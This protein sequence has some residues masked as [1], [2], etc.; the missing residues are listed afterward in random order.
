[1]KKTKEKKLT[2]KEIQY[3]EKEMLRKIIDFFSANNFNYYIWYGTFLGAVR[4]KGFIPWD[5]DIDLVMLRPEYNKLVNYLIAND[6]KI[7]DDLFAEGYELGNN[8]DFIILK[9]YNKN[10]K[11][12]D[13]REKVDKYLWIDIFP[14]DNVP[15]NNKKHFRRCKFLYKIFLLKR[16]QKNKVELMAANKTKKNIKKVIMFILKI[17]KYESYLNFF[18]NY[19]TKYNSKECYYL[20]QNV[21]PDK[22]VKYQKNDFINCNYK[23]EDLTVNSVKDYDKILSQEYG[24]YMKL[25]SEENRISHEFEAWKKEN[26]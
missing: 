14:L 6:N 17:W 24:D 9:I 20:C 23:F 25:P 26:I 19:C 15:E 5:D 21:M 12:G 1:M 11:L 2:L 22:N 7:S 18:Y 16:E 10:I 13:T 4:H 8:N 3:E